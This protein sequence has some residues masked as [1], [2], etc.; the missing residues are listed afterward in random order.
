VLEEVVVVEAAIPLRQHRAH[1]SVEGPEQLT[2]AVLLL[3][4]RVHVAVEKL[5]LLGPHALEVRVRDLQFLRELAPRKRRDAVAL[6]A[7]G[8]LDLECALAILRRA[9]MRVRRLARC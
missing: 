1:L 6:H 7:G 8:L 4:P 5:R 2:L 3:K 9:V